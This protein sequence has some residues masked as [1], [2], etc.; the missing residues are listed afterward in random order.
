MHGKCAYIY[1]YMYMKHN[2]YSNCNTV[3][4]L[5]VR[6]LYINFGKG[7]ELMGVAMCP[8]IGDV[9][10]LNMYMYNV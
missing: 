2:S 7:G 1:M 4:T 5:N 10:L 3:C 9:F 8:H 6:F